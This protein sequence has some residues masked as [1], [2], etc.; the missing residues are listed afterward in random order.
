MNIAPLTDKQIPDAVSLWTEAGL[1][2]PWNDAIADCRRALRGPDS[3]VLAVTD[4][5]GI[6]ATAMVGHDGH[7]GWVYSLAVAERSRGHGFG[8]HLM[9]ACEDW[10]RDRGIPKIQLMVRSE[11]SDVLSF[12]G[13][14]GYDR[15]DV[16]V[17]GKRLD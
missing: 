6:V 5:V 4:D 9:S 11:N 14:L 15:S 7:R 13:R 17:L 8:A 1:T 3:T 10:V 16:V 2:R 12:Y